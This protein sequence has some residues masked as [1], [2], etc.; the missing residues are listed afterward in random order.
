MCGRFTQTRSP[1]A[2]RER[3]AVAQVR[4]APAPRYNVAPTDPVAVV[5]LENCGR[6]LDELRWGLV[7][8]W[9]DPSDRRAPR[10]INARAETL[11]TSGMFRRLLPTQRCLVV[12]DGFYEW[13]GP[14][15]RRQA[16]RARL[17][18]G[19]AFGFAG[20]W[21][22]WQDRRDPDAAPL[23]TCTIVTTE[24]N[25]LVRPVHDRMP[26][27]LPPE[28]EERWLDPRLTDAAQLVAL[29]RPYPA[30][31]M[32]LDRVSALVNDVRNQSP[33]CIRPLH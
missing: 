18:D 21:D 16:F 10:P 27:I 19:A 20:L 29:L 12:A 28:A 13:S 31:R 30:E 8:S 11:A 2:L 9:G 1:E 4:A 25:R 15:A 6:V 24:A 26:V 7:P 17:A 5:L 32:A 22:C 33:D 3:F 23:R 14:R